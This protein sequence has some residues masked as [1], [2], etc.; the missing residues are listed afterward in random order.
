[1][2]EKCL[3]KVLPDVIFSGLLAKHVELFKKKSTTLLFGYLPRR[4][5]YSSEHLEILNT[6]LQL[7]FP[8]EVVVD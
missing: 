5:N 1:M 4:H 7:H 2:V 8:V 3:W 6:H